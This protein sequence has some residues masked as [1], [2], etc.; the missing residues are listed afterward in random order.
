MSNNVAIDLETMDTAS[1]AAIVS[2]GAVKFDKDGIKD[3]FYAIIDLED[4]VRL[5]LTMSP[6]TVKW[7][8]RQT[9]K[10]DTFN[11]SLSV[12]LALALIRFSEWIGHDAKV[13]GNGSDFDNVILSNAYNAC[14][15]TSPW[16]YYNNCCYRTIKNL[17]PHI[18][19]CRQGIHHNALDDATSQ[20]LHLIE[21]VKELGIEL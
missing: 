8:I 4:C 9:N 11:D 15:L 16:K 7:W 20:A 19:M 6:S 12:N 2:I 17:A 3:K 5:G 14:S 21:I 18:K 10:S 13:W 1:T